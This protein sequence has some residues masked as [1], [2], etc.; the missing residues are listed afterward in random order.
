MSVNMAEEFKP[1]LS[2]ANWQ[3][4]TPE[5]ANYN[6]A[7]GEH[8]LCICQQVILSGDIQDLNEG[9]VSCYLRVDHGLINLIFQIGRTFLCNGFFNWWANNP[10]HRTF[11]KFERNP[12][13]GAPLT[14]LLIETP[15]GILK[16]IRKIT[17]SADF[18]RILETEIRAQATRPELE[19]SAWYDKAVA[20]I[21]AEFASPEDMLDEQ[22][23]VFCQSSE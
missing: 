22:V 9:E 19:D 3:P 1:G 2:F 11:P 23:L 20:Q 13:Q 8:T 5:G 6:Y 4:A 16:A 12:D 14:I 17:L 21:Y 15:A 10:I 18:C 7:D